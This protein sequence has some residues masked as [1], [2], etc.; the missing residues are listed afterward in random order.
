MRS[1]RAGVFSLPILL[2]GVIGSRFGYFG[3]LETFAIISVAFLCAFFALLFAFAAFVE[4]WTNG[5]TGLGAAVGGLVF[6]AVGFAPA[7]LLGLSVLIYPQIT[8][9]ST[10]PIEPPIISVREQRDID[11]IER[12]AK[13]AVLFESLFGLTAERSIEDVYPLVKTLVADRGWEILRDVPPADGRRTA[14]LEMET[15]SPILRLK[16]RATIRLT[17]IPEGTLVDMRSMTLRGQHDFG[18]NLRRLSGFF[19]DLAEALQT[20]QQD[21]GPE[22]TTRPE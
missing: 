13:G 19:D 4:I 2:I 9:V 16:D 11:R 12:A 3:E 17:R 7:V 6:G 14:A 22:P 18:A 21:I 15:R 8:D 20:M 5:D 10:D 1:H